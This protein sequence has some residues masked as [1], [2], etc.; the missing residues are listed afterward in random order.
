[1]IVC[2]RH[3]AV[4]PACEDLWLISSILGI[5]MLF[6][7][8][9][10]SWS[11]WTMERNW[12]IRAILLWLFPPVL[13]LHQMFS[14]EAEVNLAILVCVTWGH[15]CFNLL[16]FFKYLDQGRAA[17]LLL[18]FGKALQGTPLHCFTDA[19]TAGRNLY[20]KESVATG[21]SWLQWGWDY[22]P[23]Q[24][25]LTP[26]A[27]SLPLCVTSCATAMPLV[28][29][30]DGVYSRTIRSHNSQCKLSFLKLSLF[31]LLDFYSQPLLCISCLM[32][33]DLF[34]HV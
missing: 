25:G 10:S 8:Q 16:L 26:V 4:T 24:H 13:P 11:E 17:V 32:K 18:T 34:F 21:F 19:S 33:T 9:D 12:S 20:H 5:S 2:L 30:E 28:S 31:Y 3:I 29:Q 6:L 7:C 22:S 15:Q 23:N 27:P 1:M 14:G